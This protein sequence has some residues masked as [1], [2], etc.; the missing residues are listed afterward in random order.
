MHPTF[1]FL[2]DIRTGAIIGRG[3][4]RQRLYYVEEVT[5]HSTV[6]LAHGTTNR[7]AWLWHRRLGHPS[8]GYLHLVFP[9]LIPSNKPINCEICLG[10]KS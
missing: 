3:I 4:E 5:Q 1:C 8:T 10:K 6:M 9:K 2:Q 7:E